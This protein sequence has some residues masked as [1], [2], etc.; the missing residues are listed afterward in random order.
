MFAFWPKAGETSGC[1][2]AETEIRNAK[3]IRPFDERDV[4]TESWLNH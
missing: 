3:P 4:E 1:A 2:K